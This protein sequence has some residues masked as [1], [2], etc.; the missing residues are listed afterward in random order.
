M[1]GATRQD[2][3]FSPQ[4]TRAVRRANILQLRARFCR[5]LFAIIGSPTTRFVFFA[6]FFFFF[7]LLCLDL[8]FSPSLPLVRF[9]TFALYSSA[10]T[11]SFLPHAFALCSHVIRSKYTCTYVWRYCTRLRVYSRA[12]VCPC[13]KRCRI[14]ANKPRKYWSEIFVVSPP[15]KL[16]AFGQ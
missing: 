11:I 2:D 7:I 13:E 1:N 8:F 3:E 6:F 14:P 9:L 4:F 12:R 5:N 16:R 10:Y 15:P